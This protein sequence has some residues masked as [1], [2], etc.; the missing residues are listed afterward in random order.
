MGYCPRVTERELQLTERDFESARIVVVDDEPM[1][2]EALRLFFELEM[3]L[4]PVVFN[5]PTQAITYLQAQVVDLIISDIM[6][7]HI[8]GIEL[9]NRVREAQPDTPR[10]LL[11]GFADKDRAVRSINE[12]GVFQFLEKPWHNEQLRRLVINVLER[13]LLM[14]RFDEERAKLLQAEKLSSVGLFA[15]GVAHEINNPLAGVMSCLKALRGGSL[16]EARREEYFDTAQ[17]ALE[18]IQATIR[19]LLDYARQREPTRIDLDVSDLVAACVK[20]VGAESRKRRVELR[21]QV[22]AGSLTLRAD[23][24][25]IMQVLVNLL[26]NALHAA[27]ADDGWVAIS[28]AVNGRRLAIRIADN[29]CGMPRHVLDRARQPFF[30]TKPEGH[31]TGLGLSVVDGIVRAHEGELALTSTEGQGT[32][33]TVWLPLSG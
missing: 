20:L 29:G 10:V 3:G 18:R 4:A 6:M 12:I 9:M 17:E 14:R 22:A 26:L 32:T 11:T 33:V 7:P 25:Q 16:N 23:R 5:D 1:I 19:D 2:T 28:A 15:A 30:T 27:P 31:G 21:N 24:G 13:K 8:D